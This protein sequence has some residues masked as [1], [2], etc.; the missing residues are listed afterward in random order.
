MSFN[1]N[2]LSLRTLKQ[3]VDRAH[4]LKKQQ[5]C[6]QE[7]TWPP[8]RSVIQEEVA[9]MLGFTSWHHALKALEDKEQKNIVSPASLIQ[10]LYPNE[11]LQWD[12]DNFLKLLHWFQQQGGSNIHIHPSQVIKGEL[13]GNTQALSKRAISSEEIHTLLDQLWGR[14]INT[15]NGTDLEFAFKDQQL[16][17]RVLAQQI[18]DGASLQWSF[19]TQLMASIPP[20]LDMFDLKKSLSDPLVNK[21]SS[22]AVISSLTG[23]GSKE[24]MASVIREILEKKTNQ[25]VHTWEDHIAFELQQGDIQASN[26]VAQH[27]LPTGSYA[28]GIKNS[29]RRRPSVIMVGEARDNETIFEAVTAAMTGHQVYTTV[30]SLGVSNMLRRMINM[31]ERD[32]RSSFF[33]DLIMSLSILLSVQ[34]VQGN[35]GVSVHLYESLVFDEETQNQ[36]LDTGYNNLS[37][38]VEKALERQQSSFWHDALKK[39]QQG[40]ISD[41]TLEQVKRRRMPLE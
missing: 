9:H 21:K 39:H 26:V 6:P 37:Y 33:V 16:R 14:P 27:T 30:T 24:L 19:S 38:E 31:A 23:H 1:P 20:K 15:L 10:S 2:A 5:S 4:K 36:L 41:K 28:R 22:L 11:P 7:N 32:E 35:N 29:L 25:I 34:Q 13:F 3:F 12:K 8:K 18:T 17:F 40:L